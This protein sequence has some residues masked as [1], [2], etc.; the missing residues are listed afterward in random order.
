[1]SSTKTV[2]ITYD[3]LPKQKVFHESTALFTGYVGGLG[4]GKTLA[5]AMKLIKY[6]L[7][8]P[9]SEVM[10]VAPNFPTMRK[11]T[12]R[13]FFQKLPTELIQNY[14]KSNH[15][16]EL[17]NESTAY[18]ASADKPDSLRGPNL[19]AWWYDEAS[20]GTHYSFEL[21]IG[22]LR[23]GKPQAIITGTPKGFNWVYD[24]FAN[25]KKKEPESFLVTSSTRENPYL[26]PGYLSMLERNY[27]GSFARQEIDGLFVGFE[28]L[29]Y[30]AFN[31]Q[32]HVRTQFPVEKKALPAYVGID[33]GYTNPSAMVLFTVDSDDRKWIHEEFYQKEVFVEELIQQLHQWKAQGYDIQSCFC[34]PSGP[35]SIEKIISSGIPAYAADNSIR[36]GILEVANHMPVRGDGL[37]GI[38]VRESSC[39]NLLMEFMN[40]RYPD[41][42]DGKALQENP[43]KLFDHSMDALRYGIMGLVSRE[44]VSYIETGY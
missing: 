4:S 19:S 43:V 20:S 23:V 35:G 8:Y 12:M 30:S 25:P 34:D 41:A 42:K 15:E 14:N 28:G 10:V 11:S 29:V 6:M 16:L 40:Y 37:P 27:S 32:V 3:P 38:F 36:E 17:L 7:E 26:A 9:G 39:P 33:F 18:F 44:R 13:T 31:P 1:M 5:G 24:I 21:L 2:R 22:R